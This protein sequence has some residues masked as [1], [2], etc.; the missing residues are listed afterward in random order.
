M[1]I[2][3]KQLFADFT[4][5]KDFCKDYFLHPVEHIKNP[6]NIEWQSAAVATFAINIIYG[7]L[8]ATYQFNVL[9][10]LIGLFITP[11]MAALVLLLTTQFLFYFFQF[12]F[13]QTYPFKSIATILFISYLPG[14]LFFL[15][16]VI[17]QP[18]FLMGVLIMSA[19]VAVGLVE[20]FKVPHKT[21]LI[22]VSTGAFLV[23]VFWVFDQFY[24]YRNPVAPKSLDQLESEIKDS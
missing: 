19:L 20:N 18:L 24:G 8:R 15:A 9:N 2:T 4:T 7:L 1:L 23:V 22:L 13:K 10:F 5:L 17:Y 3:K 12:S 16:S 6:P 14:S 21:V 11:L